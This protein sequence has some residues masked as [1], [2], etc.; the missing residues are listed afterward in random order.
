VTPSPALVWSALG[1]IYVVWGSTYLAIALMVEDLPPLLAAGAR[2]LLAGTALLAVLA[3]RG[4][5]VGLTWRTAGGAALVGLLLPAAG[6]GGV[7]VA[8]QEVPSGFAS[9]L[10]ASIPLWVVALR[11]GAGR[12][13]IAGGTLAGVAVGFAGVALLVGARSAGAPA[14][15]VALLLAAAAAWALGSFLAPRLQLPP[16]GLANVGWQMVFGGAALLLSGA[17]AGEPVALGDVG[18]AAW[19]AFAYLV[20]IGSILAYAAYGWLLANVPISKVATYAYVNPVVAVTLGALVLDEAVP[21]E[22]AAG[23]ALV[24]GAVAL[25]VTREAR[26][27]ARRGSSARPASASA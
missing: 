5:A 4:R 8:Q 10:I 9:L 6:N 21:L 20:L 25:I 26:P 18:A 23:A 14:W 7:T 24:L 27:A 13:R 11:A 3:A 22:T 16:D 12:E 1:V 19:G 17:A 15:G 2:F